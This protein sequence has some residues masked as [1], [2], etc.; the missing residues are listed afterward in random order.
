MA[1][2]RPSKERETLIYQAFAMAYAELKETNPTFPEI[3]TKANEYDII[4][5]SSE[6]KI[7]DKTIFTSK[8]KDIVKLREQI[9]ENKKEISKVISKAPSELSNKIKELRSSLAVNASL[10]KEIESLENRLEAKESIIEERNNR[11]TKKNVLISE[12]QK[13]IQLLKNR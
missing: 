11:I 10:L 1:A 9:T 13:E 3:T 8:N 2:G 4:K 6:G 5:L 7:G 12:L